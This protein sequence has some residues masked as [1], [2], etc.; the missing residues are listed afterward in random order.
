M[1]D[2]LGIET[3]I[4]DLHPRTKRADSGAFLDGETNGFRGGVEATIADRAYADQPCAWA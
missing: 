3:L 4:S 1:N 2:F